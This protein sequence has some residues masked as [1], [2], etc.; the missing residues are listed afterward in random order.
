MEDDDA[1][2]RQGVARP[3]ARDAAA[4]A[5]SGSLPKVLASGLLLLS[6]PERASHWWV[7]ATVGTKPVGVP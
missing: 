5:V 7:P 3:R 2:R 4:A 6:P 1:F